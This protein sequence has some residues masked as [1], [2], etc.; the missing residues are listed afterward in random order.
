MEVGVNQ[1]FRLEGLIASGPNEEHREKLML[2]GQ[3]VGD[4]EAELTVHNP[5]G[6]TQIEKAEWQ[7]A[8]IL[9]GRA[10]QDVWIIPRRADHARS[11]FERHD[12][13]TA[14][15]SY[16]PKLD[17]WRIVWVSPPNRELITFI[18]RQVGAEIV[19]EGNDMDGT[20]MQWIFSKVTSNSYHWRRMH[21]YDGGKTW[22]LY[23]EMDVRRS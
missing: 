9:E 21:S 16:D 22:H 18:A 7:W 10:I 12:Y 3:F 19:L 8:W 5:D 6:T 20:P 11:K 4:W 14:I 1:S 13:G 23:K 15:R 2:F 17:A